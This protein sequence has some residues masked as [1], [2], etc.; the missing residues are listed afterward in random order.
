M[1]KEIAIPD[2]DAKELPPPIPPKHNNNCNRRD[3]DDNDNSSITKLKP[4][5]MRLPPALPPTDSS[6]SL[7]PK[8]K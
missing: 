7:P 3:F 1:D 5:N 4:E 8:P 6:P 2:Y